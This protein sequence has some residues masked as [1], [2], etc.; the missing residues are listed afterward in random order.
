M[1]I[2]INACQLNVINGSK[3]GVGKCKTILYVFIRKLMTYQIRE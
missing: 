3:C 2:N 1:F